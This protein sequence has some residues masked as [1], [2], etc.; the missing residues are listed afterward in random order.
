M[1]KKTILTS[2]I[3]TISFAVNAQNWFGN[4][5]KIKGN[6]NVVTETR[7]TADYE[8]V[9]VGGSF[10]VIL[11]K[12]KEGKITIKGEENI[13][14]YLETEISKGVLKIQYKKN[15][16]INSTKKVTITVPYQHIESVALGGS[17]NVSATSLIKA[18]N[19][20]VNLGGSGNI[21]LKVT[22]DA[23]KA[24]IG[25]SGNINLEGNANDLTCSIAGS[26]SVSAYG[27][28]TEEVYANVAGSGSI[29]VT[30]KSK[31]RAKLVGSGNVYYKGNPK[32]VDAKTV[33][34]GDI[35]DKN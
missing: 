14:P 12:G 19:F 31:I 7:T 30:V 32:H 3:L 16:N 27:L 24:S 21:D 28:E 33:G 26:G 1:N 23:I 5:T 4:S 35:V 8:G 6:G 9:S 17:G 13:I 22:A 18:D 11:V 2:L 34:S 25:G 15:T 20:K 10:D 29:K